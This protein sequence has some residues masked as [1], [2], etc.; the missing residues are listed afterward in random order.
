M[1]QSLKTKCDHP[2]NSQ[3]PLCQAINGANKDNVRAL[4]MR[5]SVTVK[6]ARGQRRCRFTNCP[7]YGDLVN[8]ESDLA[9]TLSGVGSF[10]QRDELGLARIFGAPR[11]NRRRTLTSTPA[12][13][14]SGREFNEWLTKECNFRNRQLY[15][16]LA[17][18]EITQEEYNQ[19]LHDPIAARKHYFDLMWKE[20]EQRF[21]DFEVGGVQ[22][23]DPAGVNSDTS[24]RNKQ[25]CVANILQQFEKSRGPLGGYIQRA[26]SNMESA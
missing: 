14:A 5:F 19:K 7:I 21:P 26:L 22:V 6:A 24:Q 15:Y 23:C 13:T 3:K 16:D 9:R 10:D 18:G 1:Y 25:L 12:N 4:L 17:N 11:N 8:L 20:F 2:D